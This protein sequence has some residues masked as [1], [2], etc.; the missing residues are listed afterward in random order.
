MEEMFSPIKS[1]G[2]YIK[3][4][5]D[6]FRKY[7]LE[8]SGSR[9]SLVNVTSRNNEIELHVIL[10]G[11]KK[12]F[13]KL[14]PEDIINDDELLSEFSPCDVILPVKITIISLVINM[15]LSFIFVWPLAHTG[16]ALSKCFIFLV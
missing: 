8:K 12:Q 6:V 2:L 5:K 11:I 14:R 10:V 4:F 16:L 9:Y 13:L 15:I 1:I 7:K 3:K